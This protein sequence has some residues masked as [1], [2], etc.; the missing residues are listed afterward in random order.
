MEVTQHDL[1]VEAGRVDLAS[2]L[3][4][5]VPEPVLSVTQHLNGGWREGRKPRGVA[6]LFQDP[7]V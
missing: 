1:E 6:Q 4:A 5:L 7:S 2:G 3:E